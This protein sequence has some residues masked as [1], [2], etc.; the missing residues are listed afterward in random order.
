MLTRKKVGKHGLHVYRTLNATAT[1]EQFLS[2]S[3]KPG[4]K[5]TMRGDFTHVMFVNTSDL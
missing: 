2:L 1:E 4:S 5:P 3:N